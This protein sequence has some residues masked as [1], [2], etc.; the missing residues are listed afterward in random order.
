MYN[1]W[2]VTHSFGSEVKSGLNK[3][4]TKIKEKQPSDAIGG[5]GEEINKKYTKHS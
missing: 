3:N 1:K 2:D 5:R 4:R